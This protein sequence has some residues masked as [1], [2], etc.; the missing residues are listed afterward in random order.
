MRRANTLARERE[1][2]R[3]GRGSRPPICKHHYSLVTVMSI[4]YRGRLS[5]VTLSKI[6]YVGAAAVL[7]SGWGATAAVAQPTVA[8]PPPR[9][10]DVSRWKAAVQ[11][12]KEVRW[13]NAVRQGNVLRWRNVVLWNNTV[14]WNN[15]VRRNL[16]LH[17]HTATHAAAPAPAPAIRATGACGGDL[18]PCYVMMRESRGSLTARNPHST[19]SGKWQFVDG[20]WAGF[21]GYAHAYLA[22]ESVQDARAR[23][24]WA[25]GAGCAAWVAC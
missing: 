21:G 13:T 15:A 19:A 25:N 17:R 2:L 9:L 7:A 6:K 8:K 24:V 5:G 1:P 11:H 18:P 20:T 3:G 10:S 22:P 16:A 23:Q 14:H 4:T 12:N